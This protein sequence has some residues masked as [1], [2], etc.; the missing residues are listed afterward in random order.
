MPALAFDAASPPPT[1]VGNSRRGS[2]RA[3]DLGCGYH[4][5]LLRR[6][7][8][9][10]SAGTGV[11]VSISPQ[12]RHAAG[13]AWVEDTIENA[14][15]SFTPAS[16]DVIFMISVLEHLWEPLAAIQTC[17]R[18]LDSGGLLIINVPTWLGKRW[19]EFSAFRL[20]ASPA[21]E[22]NDH[23]MYYDLRDLWPLLVRAGFRPS[24]I[25]MRYH[26]FGLNLFVTC[27]KE[28]T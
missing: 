6:L 19:L 25:K 10:L 22:M 3:L 2:L 18:I 7:E 11:D 9:R 8:T 24:Q 20:S 28:P 12:A 23:K 17:W 13:L 26:K 5:L 16:Y 1:R 27:R 15:P 21:E 14:L 4:A